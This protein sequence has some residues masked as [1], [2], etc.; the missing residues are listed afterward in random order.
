MVGVPAGVVGGGVVGC[1]VQGGPP[2]VACS[3]TNARRARGSTRTYWL[4]RVA[5][6]PGQRRVRL[7]LVGSP[8]SNRGGLSSGL[9]MRWGGGQ[10]PIR[11]AV[12]PPAPL[13][14]RPMMGPAHQGQVR[15]VGGAAMEPVD[16]MMGFAP[17][18][19]PITASDG[20]A[21]VADD[22]GVALG[23]V[24]DPGGAAHLQRL[25]RG[26]TQGRGQ[27]PRCHLELGRQA[28]I[29]VG[30]VVVAGIA[31]VGVLR[32]L[33]GDQD[34]GHGAVAGQPPTRLRVQGDGATSLATQPPTPQGRGGCPGRR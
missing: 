22:Q 10:A 26:P 25:G 6:S 4:V 5:R 21:T 27:Q 2:P 31:G 24:H 8:G 3:R 1:W 30:V 33:A 9:S 12:K 23:G 11:V 18:R 34:P 28:G 13:M 16:Q 29:I 20:A 32:G 17:A 19:G 15:Q 7:R 14:H